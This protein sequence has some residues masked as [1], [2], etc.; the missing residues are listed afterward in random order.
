MKG[1]QKFKTKKLDNIKKN[2][3]KANM[4]Q[5]NYK[6]YTLN[7]RK[8]DHSKSQLVIQ[9]VWVFECVHLVV[10]PESAL[11]I[12]GYLKKGEAKLSSS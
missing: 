1:K 11:Y 5:H 10:E 3:V 2:A 4:H 8:K 12:W 9:W 7:M 6:Q